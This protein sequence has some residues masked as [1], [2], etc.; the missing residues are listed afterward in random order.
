MTDEKFTMELTEDERR[1]IENIRAARE[2][3]LLTRETARELLRVAADFW[4]WMA[5]EGAGPTYSTFCDEYGYEAPEWLAV[6]RNVLYELA[7]DLIDKAGGY[8]ANATGQG[9]DGDL[10]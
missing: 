8:A 5:E 9:W 3:K 7:L 6:K 2:R 4:R 1:V 10:P